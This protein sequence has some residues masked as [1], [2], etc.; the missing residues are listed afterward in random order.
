MAFSDFTPLRVKGDLDLP[1][2]KCDITAKD[3]SLGLICRET[4]TG[5]VFV[6]IFK[7]DNFQEELVQMCQESIFISQTDSL[8]GE[9]DIIHSS[10]ILGQILNS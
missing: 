4:E 1:D 2:S 10:A 9:D 5:L 8:L 7:I 3:A 6:L